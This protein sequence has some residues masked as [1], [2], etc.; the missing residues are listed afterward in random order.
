M[1]ISNILD[2]FMPAIGPSAAFWVHIQERVTQL[3]DQF[4]TIVEHTK[5]CFM[6]RAESKRFVSSFQMALIHLRVHNEGPLAYI[7]KMEERVRIITTEDV[8]E[9]LGIFKP[10]WNYFNYEF[11]EHIVK[12]FGTSELQQEMKEYI[13][14]L[15]LFEKQQ[16]SRTVQVYMKETSLVILRQWSFMRIGMLQSACS[17]KFV[18]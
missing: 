9:I 4:K 11:L 13:E 2:S 17:I 1:T 16:A 3:Q 5:S 15:E 8:E 6:E 12:K 10:Y 7:L 14:E 18:S